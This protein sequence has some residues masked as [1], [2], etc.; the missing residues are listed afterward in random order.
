MERMVIVED[1]DV[2]DPSDENSKRG[3]RQGK[4][5]PAIDF[6]RK[7]GVHLPRNGIPS[8]SAVLGVIV[9]D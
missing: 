3:L 4:G 9:G 5:L 6:R 7:A 2:G 8:Q 1:S